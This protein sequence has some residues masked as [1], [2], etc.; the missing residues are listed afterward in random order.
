MPSNTTLCV[1]PQEA[2]GFVAAPLVA[3]HN[4]ITEHTPDEEFQMAQ[5]GLSEQAPYQGGIASEG[6]HKV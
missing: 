5:I 6:S 4:T 2:L 3:T 1:H